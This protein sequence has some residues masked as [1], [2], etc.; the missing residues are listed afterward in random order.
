MLYFGVFLLMVANRLKLLVVGYSDL[1]SDTLCSELSSVV[2]NLQ[3][4]RAD[5]TLHLHATLCATEWDAI[6]CNDTSAPH[7]QRTLNIVKSSGR[8]IPFIIYA[9]E[10]DDQIFTSIIG[11]DVDDFVPLGNIPKLL[12]AIEREKKNVLTRRKKLNVESQIYRLA[13]YD[14]LTGLPKRNL[15]CEQV[16]K[17]LSKQDQ[18]TAFAAIY[19]VTFHRLPYINS[20]Y[21]YHIGDILIQQLSYR[22]SVETGKNCLLTRIEG[23]KFA[24]F[25][26]AVTNTEDVQSFANQITQLISAP[27]VINNLE[28]V[29]ASSIGICI[30][31]TDGKDIALLLA[32]AENTLSMTADSWRNRC[33]YY[34][35]EVEE[36]STKQLALESSLRK[37]KW[38]PIFGQVP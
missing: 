13:N 34:I 17:T 37:E 26:N 3:Y 12:F 10:P 20:T 11:S 33:K 32:N 22:L 24:Y 19:F 6:I 8:D 5:N 9:H 7:Y 29:V 21:G 31:P 18:S 16:T 25:N 35:K 2:D 4:E 38:T 1:D 27:F 23:S 28:F 30:Y 36:V 15:F 14:E